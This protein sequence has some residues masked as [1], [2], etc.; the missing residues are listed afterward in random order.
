MVFAAFTIIF[1]TVRSESQDSIILPKPPFLPLN[2]ATLVLSSFALDR[3]RI[4]LRNGNRTRFNVWW[5]AAAALGVLFLGGQWEAWLY[6][7]RIG[8][9]LD[10]IPSGSFFY[11]LTAAHAAHIAAGLAALFYVDVQAWRLRLGPAKRTFIDVATVFWHFLT[12]VWLPHGL[13]LRLGLS[14]FSSGNG[15]IASP[16]HHFFSG[17]KRKRAKCR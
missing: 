14:Y 11:M 6:L 1:A 13:V 4:A 12:V 8:L 10:T 7:R 9:H 16:A 5:T 17:P 15:S 2:T 3:S